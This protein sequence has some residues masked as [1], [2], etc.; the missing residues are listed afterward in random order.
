MYNE[1]NSLTTRHKIIF[2][3]SAVKINFFFVPWE[4]LARTLWLT[5]WSFFFNKKKKKKLISIFNVFRFFESRICMDWLEVLLLEMFLL[6]YVSANKSVPLF[7]S[8]RMLDCGESKL[9]KN[10]KHGKRIGFI[11]L[12]NL[13]RNGQ[14][15][16][17]IRFDKNLNPPK[18]EEKRKKKKPFS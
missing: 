16:K 1:Y 3:W 15:R 13:A 18:D 9:R 10:N 17:Q 12:W 5:F 7:V 14:M 4:N 2:R 11:I 6:F 8:L